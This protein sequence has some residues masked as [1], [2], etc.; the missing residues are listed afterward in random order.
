MKTI[1]EHIEKWSEIGEAVLAANRLDKFN[2]MEDVPSDYV[3]YMHKGKVGILYNDKFVAG[4]DMASLPNLNDKPE[5][6]CDDS[7]GYCECTD[8]GRHFVADD[9]AL[10]EG[11]YSDVYAETDEWHRMLCVETTRYHRWT[12]D[13]T[14]MNDAVWKLFKKY[15]DDLEYYDGKDDN[16]LDDEDREDRDKHVKWLKDDLKERENEW[17]ETCGKYHN[18]LDWPF[19]VPTFASIVKDVIE[20]GD[21]SSTL[22]NAI[23]VE[24]Q[25]ETRR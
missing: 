12:S 7:E 1:K 24:H 19:T 15:S 4:E 2:I 21:W 8:I 18:L 5:L 25:N 13:L 23:K 16:E 6:T 17:K 22:V 11:W 10:A 3:F 14:R 20:H 9:E